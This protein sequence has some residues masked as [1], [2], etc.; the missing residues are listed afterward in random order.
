MWPYHEAGEVRTGVS[1]LPT[2]EDIDL[3]PLGSDAS[4]CLK[5]FPF[6]R[7][8][9]EFRQREAPLQGLWS[10]SA[11]I[12]VVFGISGSVNNDSLAS[13]F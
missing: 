6:Q 12:L 3:L 2:F 13:C 8:C 11:I 5:N 4:R 9:A 1:S 7:K 10:F